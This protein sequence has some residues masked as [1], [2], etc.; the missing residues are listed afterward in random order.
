MG[1]V[2]LTWIGKPSIGS[3][4]PDHGGDPAAAS[5]PAQLTTR[6]A[7]IG[8]SLV[9]GHERL[10]GPVDRPQLDPAAHAAHHAARP[11]RAKAGAT[12]CGLAL[13]SIGQNAAPTRSRAR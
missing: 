11:A 13:P 6:P 1:S 4:D 2:T 7:A 9:V 5:A 10:P 3:V 12:F 8:P